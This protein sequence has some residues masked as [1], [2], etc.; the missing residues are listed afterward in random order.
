M[1]GSSSVLARNF[2][3]RWWSLIVCIVGRLH[4]LLV[5]EYYVF[6][7]SYTGIGASIPVFSAS[8]CV[9]A[10]VPDPDPDRRRIP[11]FGVHDRRPGK[12]PCGRGARSYPRRWR[13]RFHA[14]DPSNLGHRGP[15]RAEG[16]RG[17][18]L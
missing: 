12:T 6:M 9:P 3:S 7:G 4:F 11:R 15:P 13:L 17:L 1:A 18:L 8:D 5:G 16:Y 2:F 10:D 14:L